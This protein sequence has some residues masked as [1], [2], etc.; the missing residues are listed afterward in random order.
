MNYIIIFIT[1][2]SRKEAELICNELV[3][4]KL[5][6]CCN[7]ISDVKSIFFWNGTLNHEN[8][9]MI[10]AKSIHQNFKDILVRVKKIHSYDTPEIIAMP[11]IDGSDDYL[12]W[13]K[14]ETS[15]T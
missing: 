12:K 4:S 7:I 10:I 6:A 8:E 11:I 3:E 13:I 9:S 2:S 14:D 15:R 5:V 1:A